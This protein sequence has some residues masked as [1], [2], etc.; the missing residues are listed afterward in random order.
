VRQ[1]GTG[2]AAAKYSRSLETRLAR[3]VEMGRLMTNRLDTIATRQ[4][5]THTRDLLFAAFVA[6]AAVIS[7]STIGTAAS[8]ASTHIASR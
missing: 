3:R 4:R 7:A 2:E 5:G 8:A 6:L 1:G